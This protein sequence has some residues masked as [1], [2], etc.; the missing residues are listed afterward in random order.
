VSHPRTKIVCTLG[1]ASSERDAICSLAKSGMDVARLNFSHGTHDQHASRI[2]TIRSVAEELK[3]PLAILG[4]LQGP[5]IRVGDLPGVIEL[6]DRRRDYGERRIIAYG[7]VAGRVLV[8]VYTWRSA[9]E[10]PVRWIISLRK[11]NKG[12]ANAYRTAFPQ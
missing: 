2:Q 9:E 11:A 7:A 10:A 5:R 6:D 8:C 3:C 1:P 12:E 4:D